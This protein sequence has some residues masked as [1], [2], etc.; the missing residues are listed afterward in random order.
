MLPA[1]HL[2]RKR[3]TVTTTKFAWIVAAIASLGTT[4]AQAETLLGL[5]E[6]A[7]RT[8]L[9]EINSDAPLLPRGIHR[10]RGLASGQRLVTIDVR[11][12]TGEVYG[13]AVQGTNAQL[14][15]IDEDG[16]A[17]P[18]GSV[19]SGLVNPSGTQFGFDFNPTIDRVRL[20]ST[21]GQNIVF[22]PE[23]GAVTAATNL[24]YVQGDENA[25]ETPAV[26]HIAYD[27][28]TAGASAS[29]QRGIDV[30]LGV[31]VTVANNLG[32]LETIGSLGVEVT[33]VGGFDV[34]GETGTGYAVMTRTAFPLQQLFEIDLETGLADPIGVPL[35]GILPI[36]G[37]TVV[38]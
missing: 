19:Y 20:V 32:E 24:F 4:S 11:P 12:A 9:I 25:S 15:T 7:G 3:L 1:A 5:T 17:A 38:E 8:V 23:D 37:V 6:V 36:R 31:L 16:L 35:F 14:Y 30:N 22:N 13:V 27:N 18:V 10:I 2:Y 21:A 33:S 29:Q 28:N 26:A 34:S